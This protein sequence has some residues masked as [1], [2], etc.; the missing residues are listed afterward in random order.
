MEEYWLPLRGYEGRYEISDHGRCRSLDFLDAWGRKRVGRVLKASHDRRGYPC[1]RLSLRDAKTSARLHRL[2]AIAFIPNPLRLPQ[3]NHIDG[4]KT[5]NLW[6]NL[7]WSTNRD[8][9][10]HA[11]ANGLIVHSVGDKA[12][13]FDS[14]V[15]VYNNRRQHI[16]TLIG[17]ADMKAKGYDWRN[18]NACIYGTRKSHRG[19]TFSRAI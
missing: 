9:V 2:V 15:L 1:I 8:N 12:R 3:V 13:R 14:A 18:V 11:V 4:V 10:L 7:E 6:T 16:D 17:N 5:N 19:C